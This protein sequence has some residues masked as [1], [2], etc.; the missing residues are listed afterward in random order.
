MAPFF[1]M[2]G[3]DLKVARAQA[4]RHRVLAL[5]ALFF[6]GF[7]LVLGRAVY[8]QVHQ[9]QRLAEMAQGQYVRELEIPARRGDVFDRRGVALAQS[10]EVDSV[11]VD[12]SL[13]VDRRAAVSALARTLRVDTK[14]LVARVARGRRFVWVKRA[15]KP[16]E[17]VAVNKLR[18]K[19][20]GVTK[21]PRRFYP[22][23]ELAA[24]V[25]GVVGI[26][27]KGLEGLELAFQDELSGSRSR[28]P[29]FRDARGRKLLTHG[30]SD[31][32]ER[33]GAAVYLTLDRHLQYVAEKA[34]ARAVEDARATAGMAVLLDPATGEIL[35][36]AN[37]PR[38]NPNSPSQL[39]S[40]AM[41]NRA[42]L[43]VFEPGSTMKAF[44]V[45]AAL[46]EHVVTASEE[47]DCGNGVFSIGRHVIHD[48][49]PYTRL[50][51]QQILQVSSNIGAAKVA[52]RL[53]RDRLSAYY[54]AFGFGER[55]GLG[56]PGEGKGSLPFPQAEISLATQ[57]FGQ[58]MT[59]TAV[60]MAAAYGAIANRGVLMRPYLVAKVVDPDGLVLL[61]NAP[62]PVRRVVSETTAQ[63]VV[64]ML[65]TVVEREGTA[66]RAY[67]EEYRVAGKTGTAQKVDPVAKG[68]SDKRIASFVGFLPAEAPRLVALVVVDEP[69]TDVYG[70]VVAAPAFK[71]IATAA[72]PY[73]GVSPSRTA[74]VKRTPVSEAPAATDVPEAPAGEVLKS[75]VT[76]LASAGTV[77]VP[78]VKGRS[79]RIAVA[80]LLE[81]SLAPRLQGS[82]RVVAQAPVSGARVVRGTP[83]RLTLDTHEVMTKELR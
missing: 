6:T 58:G 29:G 75:A 33:Q 45:A 76:T 37:S 31:P 40:A 27:G 51:V 62:T 71:E 53:G 52:Q 63:A 15:V 12:P 55:S 56:L 50:S 2:R 21:E 17:L 32:H 67:L 28:L 7:G 22:Q 68:Y 49:H 70:G 10:V 69:K 77:L 57:A 1:A 36:M 26:E 39:E 4:G 42:A 73:L 25:L 80:A 44:S 43:D 60:Q 72:M 30:G 65:E 18:L 79:G 23:R 8:L 19:G 82:G 54:R 13:L 66:P 61:E 74:V 78:D 34:L 16:E 24:Q 20:V 81:R 47:I 3:R 14:D 11:W 48:T 35:A 41:R 9:G 83:V 59:S 5:F 38:A 64:S 46:E